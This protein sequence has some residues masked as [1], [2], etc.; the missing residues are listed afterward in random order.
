M[1]ID[2]TVRLNDGADWVGVK[3]KKN[4]TKDGALGDPMLEGNRGFSPPVQLVFHFFLPN[5]PYILRFTR[6]ICQRLS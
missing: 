3:G 1:V 4:W 6:I 2:A 5:L